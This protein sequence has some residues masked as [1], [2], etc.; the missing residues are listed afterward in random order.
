ML[1]HNIYA[2]KSISLIA[3][4][5]LAG[6]VS[7]GQSVYDSLVVL[8]TFNGHSLD[9][10]GNGLHGNFS[11]N[12]C[13][14]RFGNTNSAVI[15]NGTFDFVDIPTD[16]R[17]QPDFPFTLS[18]WF[19]PNA[20]TAGLVTTDYVDNINS[21]AWLVINADGTVEVGYG[22]GT[23][24]GTPNSRKSKKSSSAL[25]TGQ[26][27]HVVGVLESETVLR[28]YIDCVEDTG[29]YTGT[30][31][32]MIYMPVHGSIGRKDGSNVALP[33]YLNGK[34]D[35]VAIWNRALSNS[36]INALCSNSLGDNQ[37]FNANNSIPIT[38]YPNPTEDDITIQVN[39]PA[40]NELKIEI[41]NELGQA[42][43]STNIIGTTTIPTNKLADG[44][45]FI[46]ITGQD[47]VISTQRIVKQ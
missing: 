25:S 27:Y 13:P 41:L 32:T 46:R 34:I 1:S 43:Q 14:D 36:E 28:L 21:G 38:L 39:N 6:Y 47:G 11:A 18:C 2:M 12:Y 17:L 29:I 5:V 22:N 24:N 20:Y 33:Y 42:V 4:F 15:L 30:A 40:A 9:Q 26:W 31:D 44:M 7:I 16:A 10:S 35:E 8:Y 3:L 37:V 23:V 19:W 45:Y